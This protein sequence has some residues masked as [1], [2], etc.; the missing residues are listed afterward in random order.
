MASGRKPVTP[1][2]QG[3]AL[4]ENPVWSRP[5][6]DPCVVDVVH[7]EYAAVVAGA[8]GARGGWSRLVIFRWLGLLWRL[9]AS[10]PAILISGWG[11]VHCT[12]WFIGS[13]LVNGMGA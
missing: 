7:Y 8:R 13:V 2:P 11:E 10:T 12:S 6:L 4:L 5:S 3:L 9:K 1:G